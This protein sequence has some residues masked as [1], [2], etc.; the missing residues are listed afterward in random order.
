MKKY[1]ITSRILLGLIPML[2][3]LLFPACSDDEPT[4]APQPQTIV[5]VAQSADQFSIL[6]EAVVRA[7]LVDELSG[8][9][10]FTV[11]AP[12]NQAFNAAG[13][14]DVS[15]VPVEDLRN[16]LLYH[17]LSGRVL[18][19]QVT[20][21]EV[22]TLLEGANLSVVV[23]GGNVTINESASVVTADI[24]A[25]NGVIHA[26]DNVLMPP[27]GG[28]ESNSIADIVIANEDFSI[29][30]QAVLEAGLDEALLEEGPYTVFAP[31]NAA[32]ERFLA[33]AGMSAEELLA[34]D[35][36]STIL[37][38][39]VLG[40]E[41]PASAV[42]AGAVSTLAEVPF[43]VSVDPD[44]GIWING[45]AQIEDTDIMADNGI[46]HVID[47]VITPPT[48]SI[49]EIA[50]EFSQSAEP[51]FTQLVGALQRANLVDAVGGG[52]E[53]NLTVFAPTD[54]AF[55]ALYEV[56]EVDGY[57]DIDLELLTAVLTYHVVPARSFSQDLREGLTL[58]T[59]E[60]TELTV[61]LS[62]LEINDSGLVPDLL[63]VHATNGVIHVIDQ[64]LLPE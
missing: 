42:E 54:A 60:G 50:V 21:G 28:E 30:L 51:Q 39:H 38:Y 20:T 59:L 53:D 26:I 18:A 22:P 33:D 63:N 3:V 52:F 43:F 61:N 41:V 6:V 13:I 45:N 29:L 31:T 10:P 35:D 44:G 48:Q 16:I 23:A 14:T 9:G 17:V 46:I 7:G 64:V 19:S 55:E 1:F 2:A 49:A 11:F 34:S 40:A 25:S 37:L 24:E 47:Y 12:T 27:S 36:L 4:P 8:S 5:D 56:L 32:F 57:E 58:P 62:D 15:A